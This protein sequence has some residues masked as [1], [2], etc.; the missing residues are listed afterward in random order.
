MPEWKSKV[1]HKPRRLLQKAIYEKIIE[2]LNLANWV[3]QFED[4]MVHECWIIFKIKLLELVE[5][6]MPMSTP[7]NYNER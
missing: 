7:G 2:E 5:K 4:K 6:Y 3:D 1:V